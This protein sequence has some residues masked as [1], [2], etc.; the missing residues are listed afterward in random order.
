MDQEVVT[1]IAIAATVA[2]GVMVTFARRTRERAQEA[3]P[4]A[5]PTAP[6]PRTKRQRQLVANMAP[7]PQMP[8]IE[9]LVAEEAAATG[10]NDIPGGDGLDVSLKLRV[11][12]RDEVVRGGCEDGNL[13]FRIDG[14]ASIEA[15]GIDD[16][17]L[18][19]VRD[20]VVTEEQEEPE[21][22]TVDNA[23]ADGEDG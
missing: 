11:Y 4:D 7:P 1:A 21:E 8:T 12:W 2:M 6:K 3:M 16:V 14:G 19:C 5:Q 10:V 15:A 18:V 22:E 17:R 13:E 9:E 23:V 20:G